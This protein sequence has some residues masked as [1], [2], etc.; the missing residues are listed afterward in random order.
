M[1]DVLSCGYP[2]AV[3]SIITGRTIQKILTHTR[4]DENEEKKWDE[5]EKKNTR[6]FGGGVLP[7]S[8]TTP[9]HLEIK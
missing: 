1:T 5:N 7:Q 4:N 9:S 8:D 3:M 2:L 6:A